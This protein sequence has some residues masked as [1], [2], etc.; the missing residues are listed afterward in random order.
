MTAYCTYS[1]VRTIIDT[2]L[3]DP[4]ITS[5]IV[6]ADAEIDGRGFNGRAANILKPISMLIAASYVSMRDPEAVST[7]GQ[8][9]TGRL[10]ALGWRQL[11]EDQIR[12]TGDKSYMEGKTYTEPLE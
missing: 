7:G 10:D 8:S 6:L 5:L 9:S 4:D 1:E 2:D 12:R 3:E 11:A